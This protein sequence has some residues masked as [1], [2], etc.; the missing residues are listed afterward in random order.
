MIKEIKLKKKSTTT[1]GLLRVSKFNVVDSLVQGLSLA[2]GSNF[3][4]MPFLASAMIHSGSKR[5]LNS[6]S[7][8][9]P[10]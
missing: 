7:P 5:D 1:L 10:P 4:L 6:G 2:H 9:L 8:G 3:G